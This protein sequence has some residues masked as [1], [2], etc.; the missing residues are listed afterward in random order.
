MTPDDIDSLMAAAARMRQ[1]HTPDRRL[2]RKSLGAVSWQA[3]EGGH[4]I[5]L[6]MASATTGTPQSSR[7]P[8]SSSQQH[9]EKQILGLKL[10]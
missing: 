7:Q 9:L 1:Q 2:Q 5:C 6:A 3:A 10:T 4:S 8:Q